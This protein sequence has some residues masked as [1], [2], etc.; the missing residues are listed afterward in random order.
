MSSR[1]PSEFN[2]ATKPT[3]G[4]V[5]LMQLCLPIRIF[6]SGKA[7]T[8]LTLSH[9]R[10]GAVRLGSSD[11]SAWSRTRSRRGNLV[12]VPA[13]LVRLGG[14]EVRIGGAQTV[15]VAI[16]LVTLPTLLVRRR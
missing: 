12:L 4:P 5:E 11:P 8:V 15:S 2:R 7:S 14:W 16:W 1:E 3:L 13:R 6:P 10:A 9:S